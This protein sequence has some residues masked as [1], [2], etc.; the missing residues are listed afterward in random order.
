[1]ITKHTTETKTTHRPQSHRRPNTHKPTS[2]S[3]ARFRDEENNKLKVIVVGGLEEVGRNC[4]LLE[5]GNNI[6]IIDMGLQFPEEDMPGIDYIIPNISY[7]KGKE[8]NIRGVIITHAHYDHI[9]GIPHLIPALGYPPIYGLPLTNAIIK[10]RQEDYKDL[11]PLNIHNLHIDDKLR[12]GCFDLEFFHLN[13]N[14]PDSMGIVIKTP[15][16]VIVHTGDWKFDYQP[17]GEQPADLQ[18]IARIGSE[19][20]MALLSDSTNASQVGHQISEAEVGTNLE[21]IIGKAPGRI[22]IGTFA[23]LLTRVKQIIETAEKLGKV[24]ALSGFSMKSN[25][26]I[27]KELGYMKFSPKTLIDIRQIDR[28]PANKVVIVC[29][30][31]QGEKNAS[32]M[33]IANGEH[34]EVQLVPGDTVV[35]SSSVIPGN[36]RTVQRLKDTLFRKGADVI[37]YQMMDVHA[38][39]HAKM[40]DVKL[41]IRLINPKYFVPIEG[42]HFLLHYNGK[43]AESMGFNKDNIFIADNGQVMEFTNGTGKLTKSKICSDY[44]FVDGL[45]V[46]DETNVVLRDRQ[47]LAEDGMIVVIATVDSKTGKLVQN[48][49]IISRGFV[50]LK[51]NKEL[52]EDL[53]HRVKKL[54]VDSD[55]LSWAD[56]NY[57][58]NKIRDYVGQFLYTKTEKRPMVLPVVI[59]V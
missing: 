9:G 56:T 1:M 47:V 25:V 13:H 3:F 22:I 44:V 2:N 48:P 6:I 19:G 18:K 4:T 53:R 26:A 39:G 14:I 50:F 42:N 27:A 31:A 17:A 37:H 57:I 35:F 8:K 20:V 16:G 24:V 49:D 32:L 34:R 33:R 29:T 55:P 52:I 51:S 54:V 46:S 59:E 10:K 11:K 12:L 58:R 41:M 7:L 28:Y 36:E 23:S 5:Y 38:G 43:V 15:E 45:G 21:E 30:G 40:D